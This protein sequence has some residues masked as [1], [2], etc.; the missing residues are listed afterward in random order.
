MAITAVFE[1]EEL[2]RLYTEM[3]VSNVVFETGVVGNSRAVQQR[4]INRYDPIRTYDI[5]FG[6]MSQEEHVAL[7]EFFITKS[8]KGIG[9]RFYPPNDRDFIGDVIGIG[10][11]TTTDFYLRRNYFTRSRFITRRI[12]KPLHP[13]LTVTID[14][15]KVRIDD[16]GTLITPAGDF[17]ITDN[18]I[19]VDWNEGIVTFTTPPGSGEIVRAA[20]GKYHVPVYFDTDALQASDYGPFADAN[21]VRLIEILPSALSAAGNDMPDAT[22]SFE[23]PISGI[24]VPE[25]FDVSFASAG[26]DSVML[27]LDDEYHGVSTDAPDF[28]FEDVPRPVTQGNQFTVKALGVSAGGQPILAKIALFG[29]LV[30]V[31]GVIYSTDSVTFGGDR[32]VYSTWTG[33]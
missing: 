14:D 25:T 17:P 3:A 1:E 7:Q 2:N 29:L 16:N 27:Y 9:F 28:P 24:Q 11:G 6:G 10:D 18:P 8:G 23:T 5:Q 31:D 26:L 4:N 12:V 20:S 32:V 15:E 21:S 22:L 19:T 30:S 13:Y 33:I